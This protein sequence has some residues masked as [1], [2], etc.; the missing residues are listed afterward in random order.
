MTWRA[1]SR[2]LASAVLPVALGIATYQAALAAPP[3]V[4]GLNQTFACFIRGFPAVPD[5]TTTFTAAPLTRGGPGT[6]VCHFSDPTPPTKTVIYENFACVG[7]PVPA[8]F[9]KLIVTPGGK[10]TLICHVGT[11]GS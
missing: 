2:L 6:L 5:Q 1:M 7:A 11:G 10:V 4:A 8:T 9:S 3:P